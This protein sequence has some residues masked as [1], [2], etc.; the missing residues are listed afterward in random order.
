MIVRLT[1]VEDRAAALAALEDIFF[2]SALRRTFA[3]DAERAAFLD[4]WTGWYVDQAPADVLFWRDPDGRCAGYLTGCRD[5]A[6]ATDLFARIPNY[7][8][9]ADLFDRFP[10]H[11]HINVHPDHR[12]AGVGARLIGRFAADLAAEGR[13][14]LHV[15]TGAGARNTAF[16]RRNGFTHAVERGPLLFLGRAL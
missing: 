1:D 12:D 5:S 2:R 8:L 15:V 3:S 13:P 14:G 7:A 4:T 16:Y 11:L 9:F 10:G 6:A